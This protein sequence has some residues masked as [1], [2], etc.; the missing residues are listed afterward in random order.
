MRREP[1]SSNAARSRA[2]YPAPSYAA[3]LLPALY[4]AGIFFLSSFD[5]DVTIP[6]SIPWRD[7]G[8]HFCEYLGL[9]FLCA[10][11]ARQSWPR[12]PLA[13]ILALGALI[14]TAWGFGDEIHQAFVPGRSADF[15]DVV[16]DFLGASSGALICG[17]AGSFLRRRDKA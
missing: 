13:R 9:G 8:V 14:A 1:R 17:L 6:E 4:M 16:A 11:A 15:A 2:A 10:H 3:W 12:R 5:W 7:K